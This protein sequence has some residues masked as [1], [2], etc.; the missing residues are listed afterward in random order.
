MS[1]QT[2]TALKREL[3]YSSGTPMMDFIG[4]IKVPIN[5]IAPNVNA[6]HLAA[7]HQARDAAE[8]I[9]AA[10]TARGGNAAEDKEDVEPCDS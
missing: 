4:A 9:T 6:V 8:I 2:S 10:E 5:S 3:D 1:L 7:L